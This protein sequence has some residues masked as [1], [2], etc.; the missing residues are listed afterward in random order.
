MPSG[1]AG[2]DAQEEAR[3]IA[4]KAVGIDGFINALIFTPVFKNVPVRQGY[5]TRKRPQT[6]V[7]TVIE[8]LPCAPPE[9]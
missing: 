1:P 8:E 2:V 6:K 4:S 3:V 5:F 9:P 7:Y